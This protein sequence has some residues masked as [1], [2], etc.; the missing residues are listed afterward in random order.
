MCP[1]G[2]AWVSA[3]VVQEDASGGGIIHVHPRNIECSYRGKCH[4]LTGECQCYPGYDGIACQRHEC[5]DNCNYRGVCYPER[6]FAINAGVVYD[7]PLDAMKSVGCLCD[8]GYRGNAC[9]LREC[10]TGPDPLGGFG[11]ESGRDCSGR[12]LCNYE[13]GMYQCF[14]GF[15]GSRCQHNRLLM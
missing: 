3:S 7:Q 1:K 12:G 2:I 14:Q 10:H 4:R 6:I 9:E 8:I 13:T 5:P 15:Y 11:N